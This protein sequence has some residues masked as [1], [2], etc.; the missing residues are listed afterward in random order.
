MTLFGCKDIANSVVCTI[1]VFILRIPVKLYFSYL[2]LIYFCKGKYIILWLVG[3]LE[4]YCSAI[5]I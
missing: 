4:Q 2:S 3:R 1:K 5:M